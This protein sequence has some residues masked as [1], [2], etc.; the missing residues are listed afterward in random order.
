MSSC[1]N[2][3]LSL[4]YPTPGRP[5][6]LIYSNAISSSICAPLKTEKPASCV[7]R[8]SSATLKKDTPLSRCGPSLV[9]RGDRLA[10]ATDSVR[11]GHSHRAFQVP[12][13]SPSER[14]GLGGAMLPRASTP[15]TVANV[16]SRL[17]H[18][19]PTPITVQHRRA[20]GLVRRS[21]PVAAVLVPCD[22]QELT[23]WRMA[24]ANAGRDGASCCNHCTAYPASIQGPATERRS[25]RSARRACVPSCLRRA[26]TPRKRSDV[27][28]TPQGPHGDPACALEAELI[29]THPASLPRSAPNG[30][31]PLPAIAERIRDNVVASGAQ[32]SLCST[33]AARSLRRRTWGA[34]RRRRA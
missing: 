12:G 2:T 26:R 6:P 14:R 21:P 27:E 4:R 31:R 7:A 25:A 9:C 23:E 24:V 11:I 13:V 1:I 8:R 29:D 10:N 19:M 5:T 22:P 16:A 3:L 34:Q 18:D 30:R 28:E 20:P 17:W 33:S 15:T 32:G